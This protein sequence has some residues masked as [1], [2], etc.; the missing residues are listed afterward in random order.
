MDY[1]A[2]RKEVAEAHGIALFKVYSMK[3]TAG[4]LDKDLSTIGVLKVNIFKF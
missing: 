4:F 3:Q 1:L 2:L